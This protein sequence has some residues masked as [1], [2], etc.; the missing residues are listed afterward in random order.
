MVRIQR[1][2][3]SSVLPLAVISLVIA[4]PTARAAVYTYDLVSVPGLQ[5]GA[6]LVGNI[7]VDTT[8]GTEDTAISGNFFIP[9][10]YI[11]AWNFTVSPIVGGDFSGSHTGVNASASG[12]GGSFAFY[13]TPTTLSVVEA[14][15]LSLKSDTADGGGNLFTG[16]L[17]WDYQSTSQGLYIATDG[18][19][20]WLETD[21][22]TLDSSFT[23]YAITGG[24]NNWVIAT[25]VPEPSVTLMSL[26]GALFLMRRRR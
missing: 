12:T 26:M 23:S 17:R 2:T 3:N 18:N 7:T 4:M 15:S 21:K 19:A 16:E 5:N 14:G 1:Y 8:L 9:H 22:A 6:G 24:V 10:N 13:A 25:A 11:I 20:T